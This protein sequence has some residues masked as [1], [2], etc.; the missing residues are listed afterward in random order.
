VIAVRV[1]KIVL[2]SWD[3][4][5]I[6]IDLH[7]REEFNRIFLWAVLRYEDGSTEALPVDCLGAW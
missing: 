3:Q 2:G 5:G 7:G 1:G 4:P 6:I